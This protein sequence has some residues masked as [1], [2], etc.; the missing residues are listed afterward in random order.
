MI[1]T[2]ESNLVN[3]FVTIECNG[4]IRNYHSIPFGRNWHSTKYHIKTKSIRN[5]NK[6]N[7]QYRN[8]LCLYVNATHKNSLQSITTL[9]CRLLHFNFTHFRG[10]DNFNCRFTTTNNGINCTD[11][12]SKHFEIIP[13]L[14]TLF[15]QPPL[16]EKLANDCFTNKAAMQLESFIKTHLHFKSF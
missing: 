4:Y 3:S 14:C 7:K 9:C 12:S 2:Y 5:G 15:L 1:C 6:W 16:L 13:A 10:D 11:F 8:S